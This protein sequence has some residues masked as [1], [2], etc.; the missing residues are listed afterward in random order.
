M[1]LYCNLA[2]GF[3]RYEACPADPDLD[4]VSDLLDITAHLHVLHQPVD[5]AGEVAVQP[6]RVAQERAANL[7]LPAVTRI[8]STGE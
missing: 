7:F 4:P 2:Q 3:T 8:F 1:T 5:V 6:V